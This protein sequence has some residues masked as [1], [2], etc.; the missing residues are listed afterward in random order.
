[1]WCSR[2]YALQRFVQASRAASAPAHEMRAAARARHLQACAAMLDR[3]RALFP[4]FLAVV[5]PLAGAILAVVRVAAGDRDDG[6][7]LAAASVLGLALYAL[8]LL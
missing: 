7:R 4:Y 2:V 6:L 1:M 5:L 3:L 8:V